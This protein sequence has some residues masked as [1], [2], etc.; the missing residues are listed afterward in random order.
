MGKTK[1]RSEYPCLGQSRFEPRKRMAIDGVL[2]WCVWD[3]KKSEW[4]SGANFV[5][6]SKTRR[7]ALLKMMIRFRE[8]DLPFEPDEKGKDLE[9][10]IGLT[11][12]EQAMCRAT[13]GGSKGRSSSIAR[14]TAS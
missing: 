11:S 8:G 5:P 4:S 3:N 2:W 13:K 6:K 12:L 1:Y 9:W 14:A 10:L 7:D